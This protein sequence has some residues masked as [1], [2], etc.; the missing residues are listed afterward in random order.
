MCVCVCVLFMPF[1]VAKTEFY[2]KINIVLPALFLLW[3]RN[4]NGDDDLHTWGSVALLPDEVNIVLII[5][6][7][8]KAYYWWGEV[9]GGGGMEVVGR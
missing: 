9:G 8:H 4:G 2:I 3:S 6:I 1:I 7:N 5:N